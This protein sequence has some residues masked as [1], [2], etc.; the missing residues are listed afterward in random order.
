MKQR[1]GEK[2]KGVQSIPSNR[3]WVEGEQRIEGKGRGE[4]GDVY[5][6]QDFTPASA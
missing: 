3:L 1:G 2:D 4:N 6:G 5:K